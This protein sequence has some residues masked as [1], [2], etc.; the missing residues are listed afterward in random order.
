MKH[1]FALLML[2]TPAAAQDISLADCRAILAALPPAL[3]AADVVMVPL[4]EPSLQDGWC[5]ILD[6]DYRPDASFAPGF[7]LAAV[8]FRGDGLLGLTQG[9]PPASLEVQVRDLAVRVFTADAAMN[10]L[11]GVQMARAGVDMDLS[12]RYDADARILTLDRFQADFPGDNAV[13]ITGRVVR[14]DL[15]SLS[16]L[17]YSVGQ[18]GLTDLTLNIRSHGLFENYVVLPLGL[19]LLQ[20]AGTQDPAAAVAGLLDKAQ[21]TVASLPDTLMDAPSR[22]AMDALLADL[23]NPWGHD[24]RPCHAG[25]MAARS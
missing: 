17:Q 15:T 5:T 9:I 12:L 14:L 25:Q 6:W 10:Y 4:P 11:M 2:A 23:P 22:A 24:R 16:G 1:L 21:A 20:M 3:A 7:S 18:A 8:R 13:S 19:P